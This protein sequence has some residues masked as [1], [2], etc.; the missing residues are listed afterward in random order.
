MTI[1]SGQQDYCQLDPRRF[2]VNVSETELGKVDG[3]GRRLLA[4]CTLAAGSLR[5]RAMMRP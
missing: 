3:G 4:P 2:F 5:V 1:G